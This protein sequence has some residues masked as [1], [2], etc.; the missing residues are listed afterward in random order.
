MTLTCPGQRGWPKRQAFQLTPRPL[1]KKSGVEEEL[2]QRLTE[3]EANIA[4]QLRDSDVEDTEGVEAEPIRLPG[5]R[6]VLS[7]DVFPKV[8]LRCCFK[9]R[10]SGM[11]HMIA[12]TEKL[13]C[14]RR[15]TYNMIPMR[16]DEG[17]PEQMEFC[18]QCR[19]VIGLGP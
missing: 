2:D 12:D 10:L 11:V 7:R 13:S 8:D 17:P 19:A 5:E 18:E 16:G 1:L 15:I 4:A 6:E 9:H 14:G 3:E